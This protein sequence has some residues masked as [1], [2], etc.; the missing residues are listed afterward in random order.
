[1]KTLLFI[2]LFSLILLF[3]CK[4]ENDNDY[5]SPFLYENS[6]MYVQNCYFQ[7]GILTITGVFKN[8]KSPEVGINIYKNGIFVVGYTTP[9]NGSYFIFK[10]PLMNTDNVQVW[11]YPDTKNKSDK[12]LLNIN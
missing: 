5:V 9:D 12:Y 1:M 11:F 2:F 3:S 7:N 8:S 10:Q 6:S 4:R